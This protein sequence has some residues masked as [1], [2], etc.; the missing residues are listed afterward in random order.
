[1]LG[2]KGLNLF[3]HSPFFINKPVGSFSP[4]Q[5]PMKYLTLK[6]SELFPEL[7]TCID[8][9]VVLGSILLNRVLF[10]RVS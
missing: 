7:I 8:I 3:L 2:C 6:K 5:L 4:Y 1:M 9:S 10:D